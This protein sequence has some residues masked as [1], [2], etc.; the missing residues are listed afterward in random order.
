MNKLLLLLISILLSACAT[1]APPPSTSAAITVV[2]GPATATELNARYQDTPRNCGNDSRPAFLCSGV[3]LRTTTYSDAYDSWDPSPISEK[4]GSISFSYLRKDNN[5]V[6]F[7]W[8]LTNG[9]VIYPI[10][11]TPPD[12]LKVPILCMFPMDGWTDGR[13]ERQGC[14]IYGN[15]ATSKA[16]HQLGITTGAQWRTNYPPGTQ[17]GNICGFDVRDEL[18]DYAGQ[19]FY[20]ALQA[21]WQDSRYFAEHNEMLLRAWSKG[22]GSVLPI[23]AFFYADAAGLANARK[24]K[25]RFLIRTKIDLPLIKITLP[26][27]AQGN[28]SFQYLAGDQR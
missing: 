18:N 11:K 19:N 23:Q 17:G 13:L 22:Q 6:A 25:Q 28:A 2:D 12:K 27:Q 4:K 14:G 15:N 9:Y 7:G 20:A 21:K 1:K 3:I 24:D 26:A 8:R 10:L 16:C 5:F